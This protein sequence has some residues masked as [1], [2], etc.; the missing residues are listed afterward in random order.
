MAPQ[1][2]SGV[3]TVDPDGDLI[4]KVGDASAEGESDG[5]ESLDAESLEALTEMLLRFEMY[6]C[7]AAG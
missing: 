2:N 3:C 4:P 6:K 1:V 7:S 5:S